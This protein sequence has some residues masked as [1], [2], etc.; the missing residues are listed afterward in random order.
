[1]TTKYFNGADEL[2]SI[3]PVP[4]A[5]FMAL[6]GEKSSSN[7]YDSFKRIV[8]KTSDGRVLPVQRKIEYKKFPSKHECNSKCVNGKH[9]GACECQCGGKN[10]GIGMFT[11]LLKAA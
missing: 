8:G 10:H 11:N 7:Q 9:N 5:E 4:N 3:W 1:M 2:T 6:G